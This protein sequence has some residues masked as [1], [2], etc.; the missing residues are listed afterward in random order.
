VRTLAPAPET[1]FDHARG[2]FATGSYRG[3]IGRADL[4]RA[5]LPLLRRTL[6]LKK[7]VY[8]ALVTDQIVAAFAIVHL[9]YASK[10]FFYVLDRGAGKVLVEGSDLGGPLG[11]HVEPVGSAGPTRLARFGSSSIERSGDRMT[12]SSSHGGF[13][14]HAQAEARL[15]EMTAVATVPGG[16]VNVTEK[17]VLMPLDGTLHAGERTFSLAGGLLGYD[18]TSGLL[19]RHTSWRW[20]FG[21]GK[22]AT[23]E[24]FAINLVSGFVGELE[25]TA[26]SG[27]EP[28][29]VSEPVIDVGD[30]G[31]PWGIRGKD[32][33]LSAD[34]LARHEEKTN[35]GVIRSRFIQATGTFRG[36]VTLGERQV[37]LGSVPGMIEDQDVLW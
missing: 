19:A 17:G 14:L 37:E 26:W 23:G 31:R 1:A 33:D 18:H 32:L 35:L 24:P 27:G 4:Q 7:W 3:R 9:G 30:H 2:A 15:P 34:E 11:C 16:V 8:V 5:G 22:D 29:A 36:R 25:C 6:A 28:H 13:A 20:A 21:M 12:V 10:R